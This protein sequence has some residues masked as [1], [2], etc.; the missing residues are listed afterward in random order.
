MSYQNKTEDQMREEGR[1]VINDYLKSIDGIIIRPRDNEN[2]T[3][4]ENERR[5]FTYIGDAKYN[6]P[7]DDAYTS[8]DLKESKITGN[9]YATF[10]VISDL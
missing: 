10:D 2:T 1:I 5:T 7:L 3:I 8:L 4:M 6:K 9:H